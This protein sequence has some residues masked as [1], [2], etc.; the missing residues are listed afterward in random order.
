MDPVSPPVGKSSSESS[1]QDFAA[2]VA[3]ALGPVAQDPIVSSPESTTPRRRPLTAE[4]CGEAMPKGKE[5]ISGSLAEVVG[6]SRANRRPWRLASIVVAPSVNQPVGGGAVGC[7]ADG[8]GWIEVRN[9][10]SRSRSV[11]EE[12]RRP[13]VEDPRPQARPVP[14]DLH[15][16]CFNCFSEKHQAKS[17]TAPPSCFNCGLSGHRLIDC[18]NERK[19]SRSPNLEPSPRVPRRRMELQ[20]GLEA[21]RRHT[22]EPAAGRCTAAGKEW[23]VADRV[24][25]PD[26]KSVV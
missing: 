17:C 15:G 4:G 2:A 8:E 20:G 22:I 7:D 23:V 12:P 21:D 1:S 14:A 10:R 5:P 24:R 3:A 18:T 26:R 9:R 16:L 6:T 19:R 13:L 25:P 11:E